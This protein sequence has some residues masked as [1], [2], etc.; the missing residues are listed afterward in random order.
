MTGSVCLS[1]NYFV[2]S[3]VHEIFAKVTGRIIIYFLAL[4]VAVLGPLQILVGAGKPTAEQSKDTR[5]PIF[6][7]TL[8]ENVAIL[9]GTD[10]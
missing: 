9:A 7:I 3:C 4:N 8:P 10:G 2:T 1:T 5:V 6:A